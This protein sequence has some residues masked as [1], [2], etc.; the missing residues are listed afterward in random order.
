MSTFELL[1]LYSC[2][3]SIG[4]E[5]QHHQHYARWKVMQCLYQLG[6]LF[7]AACFMRIH[8]I[9]EAQHLYSSS[10][11]EIYNILNIYRCVLKQAECLIVLCVG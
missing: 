4:D 3:N 10:V 1:R 7:T 9:M 5:L 6:I 8:Q 2:Y 11:L